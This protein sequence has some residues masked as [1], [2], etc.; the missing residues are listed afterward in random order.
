MATTLRHGAY[1]TEGEVSAL[2]Q[3]IKTNDSMT[4]IKNRHG[5]TQGAI[6]SMLQKIAST[7]HFRD[8]LP[9][10][11]IQ[12][13][14]GLSEKAVNAVISEGPKSGK[15][16]Y[17]KRVKTSTSNI[18]EFPIT[19]ERLHNISAEYLASKKKEI[20]GNIVKS[21]TETIIEIAYSRVSMLGASIPSKDQR[22][23]VVPE[24]VLNKMLS[25]GVHLDRND[26]IIEIVAEMKK[27]FPDMVIVQDPLNTYILFDWN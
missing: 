3:A 13:V 27:R 5:R 16:D 25:C 7:C 8:K 10:T 24:R 11:Q 20:I 23:Y 17:I 2:L 4:V 19:K 26:C 9:T 21:F 22:Q 6:Q 14:T 15:T 18:M 12:E 1:W